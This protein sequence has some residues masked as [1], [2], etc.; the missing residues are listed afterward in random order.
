MKNPNM[1]GI[2]QSII[3]LVDACR[4]SAEGVMVIF[5][6]SHIDAPTSTGSRKFT[7]GGWACT[8]STR[9]MPRNPLSNGT[10]ARAGFH[11]YRRPERLAMPSGVGGTALKMAR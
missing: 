2:I 9:S 6:V 10:C 5:C 8:K 1:M 7:G 11:V 4:G 3:R